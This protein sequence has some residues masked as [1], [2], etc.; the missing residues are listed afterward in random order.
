M[1]NQTA[2]EIS[3]KIEIINGMIA[4]LKGELDRISSNGDYIASRAVEYLGNE[5]F[6]LVNEAKK[7]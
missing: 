7:F 3:K 5:I 1:E 2:N 4:E 6:N